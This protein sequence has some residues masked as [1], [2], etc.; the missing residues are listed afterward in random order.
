MNKLLE[1]I[2]CTVVMGLLFTTSIVIFSKKIKTVEEK[3]IA[4]LQTTVS[5]IYDIEDRVTD[6]EKDLNDMHQYELDNL[7]F[8]DY[9]LDVSD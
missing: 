9:D 5:L 2:I 7:P 1:L 4:M 6:V 8:T 3:S